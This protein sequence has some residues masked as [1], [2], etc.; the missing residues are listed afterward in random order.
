MPKRGGNTLQEKNVHEM[1]SERG[2][3]AVQEENVHEMASKRGGNAPQEENVLE[4]TPKPGETTV[5]ER[6][7]STDATKNA[8]PTKGRRFLLVRRG[9]LTAKVVEQDVL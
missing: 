2:G 5:A 4:S 7:G 1:T 8:L 6:R 3:N 9:K